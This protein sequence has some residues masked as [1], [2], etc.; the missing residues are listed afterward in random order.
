MVSTK[1]IVKAKREREFFNLF[2]KSLGWELSA[3]SVETRPE[4][5]P[6]ILYRG[7][8]GSIAF[9]LAEICASDVAQQTAHLMKSGGVSAI[10]TSDPTEDILRKK[11]AKKYETDLQIELLLYHDGRVVT[12]D[13]VVVLVIQDELK[14]HDK[15]TFRRIWFFGEK[16]RFEFSAAGE[17][18]SSIPL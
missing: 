18:L 16:S 14:A 15:H 4:P 10:W 2:A 1:Q 11:L 6:D 13:N 7:G 8:H 3:N 12:P 17:I 9:E 5:E